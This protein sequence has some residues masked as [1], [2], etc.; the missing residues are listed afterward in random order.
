MSVFLR[1]LTA[2]YRDLPPDQSKLDRYRIKFAQTAK[3]KA[4]PKAITINTNQTA[5]LPN[6]GTFPYGLCP[7]CF[8]KKG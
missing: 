6:R 7:A 8:S 1:P 4:K 3:Y 2:S 5:I